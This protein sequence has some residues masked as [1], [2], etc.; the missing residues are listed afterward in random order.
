M[1]NWRRYNGAL[2]PLNPPHIEVDTN[3]VEEKIRKENVFFARWTSNFDCSK[4]TEFWYVI[5]DKFIPFDKLSR[6]TRNNVRR[7]LKRCQV[8]KVSH[9]FIME[10]AYPIYRKA[11]DNYQGHLSPDNEDEFLK[12]YVTYNDKNIWDF[13]VV[14]E[15][16]SLE[17]IAFSRNK[18]E[19]NQC[20]LCTTKF[21]PKFQRKYYPS[22][23]LF[24]TMNQ[25][26]LEEKRF[27]YV[28]D[29][30]RS[31]S[32]ETNIQE[33]LIQKFKFRKA[34]CKLNIVYSR[35]I[36]SLILLVYPFRWLIKFINFGLFIKL[37]I[38]IR[39]ESIRRSYE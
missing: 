22:E 10:N 2:I 3:G 16:E 33:F 26:Y 25:Y 32:H 30:A 12:E 37:N 27:M 38:L 11:F 15:K 4:E 35:Y 28:N 1:K 19:F 24:Y 29:G 34:Y 7:G 17:M 31:I 18:I 13:W 21:H 20:E 36:K 23:A 5:C 6:N 39:Q 9:Q 14:F 8:K